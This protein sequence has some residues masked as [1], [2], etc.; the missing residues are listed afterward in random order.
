[1]DLLVHFFGAET[2]REQAVVPLKNA[3][4]PFLIGSGIL[5]FLAFLGALESFWPLALGAGLPALGL[6]STLLILRRRELSAWAS[7]RRIRLAFGDSIQTLLVFA[8]AILAYVILLVSGSEPR[9][10]ATATR[11]NSLSPV[12]LELLSRVDFPVQVEYFH[13]KLR[14]DPALEALKRFSRANRNI[15]WSFI[16]MVKD[17]LKVKER[18]VEQPGTLVFIAGGRPPLRLYGGELIRQGVDDRGRSTEFDLSEERIASVLL[19]FLEGDR[20]PVSFFVGQGA[21]RTDDASENGLTRL[22]ETLRLA[23][24][25]VEPLDLSRQDLPPRTQLLAIIGPREPLPAAER[26]KISAFLDRGGSLFF[27]LDPK[28]DTQRAD[29]TWEDFLSSR[30]VHYLE[31]LVIDPSDY[32]TQVGSMKGSPVYPILDYGSPE[33]LAPLRARRFDTVFF[34]ARSIDLD[35]KENSKILL[36]TGGQS[37]GIFASGTRFVFTPGRDVRGPLPVGVLV[38]S[39]EARIAAFGDSDFLRNPLLEVSGHRDFAVAVMRELVGKKA[40]FML[41][42]RPE[43]HARLVVGE[44]E[45]RWLRWGL[46]VGVPALVLF[47]GF[48]LIRRR[49]RGSHVDAA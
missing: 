5:A 47:S 32:L 41:P 39:A 43:A 11:R 4:R 37:M 3:A 36:R 26:A 8:L 35:G 16:D 44:R 6:L 34:T 2:H 23:N 31:N 7:L 28:V 17:P 14:D 46:L 27:C 10:D 33:I 38:T 30:G 49:Q 9:F 48:A 12:T 22:R 15:Q 19:G 29:R 25:L 18:H 42:A 24:F 45:A 1:V 21:R 40:A 20:V 13:L